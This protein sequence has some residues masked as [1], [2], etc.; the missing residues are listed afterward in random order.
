[1][2]VLAIDP[3][4][5]LSAFV[6]WDG[7]TVSEFGKWPNQRLLE[8][9]ILRVDIRHMCIEKIASYGMA[10]GAEVFET[11]YWSGRF[12]QAFTGGTVDR[13]AR[14]PIK[15]H[16]CHNP[17]AN[18]ASIR[19]AIIDRFGGKDVAI[20][21]KANPGPLFGVKADTWAA[22]AVALTWLDQ[23]SAERAVSA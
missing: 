18:D 6:V 15:M 10:V 1:M 16:L 8:W 12:A 14:I 23:H 3:G 17:R 4:P 20:G 19:Q 9:I 11:C 13:I 2:T 7:R 22:L 21:R 5:E